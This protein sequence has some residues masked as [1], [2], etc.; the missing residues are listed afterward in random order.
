MLNDMLPASAGQL[1]TQ[2]PSAVAADPPEAVRVKY[3]PKGEDLKV[4]NVHVYM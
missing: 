1:P 2:S 3:S 4:E